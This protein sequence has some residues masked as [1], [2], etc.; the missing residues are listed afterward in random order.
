V[1]EG[2]TALWCLASIGLHYD[3]LRNFPARY[4][5]WESAL[6]ALSTTQPSFPFPLVTYSIVA[7]LKV[8]TL[9]FG[10]PST[11]D[12][13]LSW[14]D[15][16]IFPADTAI[17]LPDEPLSDKEPDLDRVVDHQVSEACLNLVVDYL[18]HYVSGALPYNVVQTL[19]KMIDRGIGICSTLI[20][21]TH[22]MRLANSIHHIFTDGQTTDLLDA[23]M[24]WRCWLL[25]TDVNTEDEVKAHR[26]T[27]RSS[28]PWLDKPLLPWLDN[29]IAR[30]KIGD[31][32]RGHE[33][34]LLSDTD[35]THNIVPC[36]RKILQGFD[37]WHS[38][39]E[40]TDAA[41]MQQG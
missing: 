23:I 31:A 41:G 2:F 12:G 22:Q 16:D 18:E 27:L 40:G 13:A 26:E 7:H 15:R 36:L 32:S 21:L 17:P 28:E 38:V 33:Q 39:L 10:R 11:M 20:H 6:K 24:N 8:H 29:P 37:R 1:R 3:V 19:D 25:Y 34:R 14:L 9:Q 35:S 4:A 5:C 30:Q